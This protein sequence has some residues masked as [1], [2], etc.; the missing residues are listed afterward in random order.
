MRVVK[1]VLPILLLAV[2]LLA[3]CTQPEQLETPPES[4]VRE[5]GDVYSVYSGEITTINYLVT[6]TTAEFSVAANTVDCLVEYD[7]LG[8]V[9]P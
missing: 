3:G 9:R 1:R 6:S 8:I 5:S 7:N 4:K 2:V